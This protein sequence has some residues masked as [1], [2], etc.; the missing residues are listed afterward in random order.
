MKKNPYPLPPARI[1]KGNK[2]LTHNTKKYKKE[3]K[4][5]ATLPP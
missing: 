4:N 5:H 1:K 2:S 3:K